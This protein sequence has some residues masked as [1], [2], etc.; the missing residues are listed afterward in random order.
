MAVIGY[1]LLSLIALIIVLAILTQFLGANAAG[2]LPA[3]GKRTKV[4]GAKLHWVEE[5]DGPP[6]VMIHGLGG[7]LHH[8]KYAMIDELKGDFRCIAVDRPGCGWSE[9]DGPAQATLAE[10]ARIIA[11]FIE[12]EGLGAPLIVGHSLGGAIAE[13]MAIN[14][15]D[16]VGAIALICPATAEVTETPDA[17]KGI[18]IPKPWLIPALGY[19]ISGAAGLLLEKKIF[20]EVFAPEA[21]PT[22][23]MMK[24]G[25]VLGRR[26]EAFISA[27]QDLAAARASVAQV[28]GREGEIAAPVGVLY[29]AA[30]NILDPKTHGEDFAEKTGGTYEAI[31]G[32]GHMIPFTAPGPCADFVRE[33]AKRMKPKR[34]TK[35]K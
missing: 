13:T 7:N 25:G 33:M 8:F 29:G 1:I 35:A 34:K 5:G 3:R 21:V 11:D 16:K 14:H 12:A 6:V 20:A 2:A 27:A 28:L 10:Q 32:K 30:D 9:R 23:F 4:R 31:E 24:G 17:F 18:D 22:D 15:P 19:T 26:P